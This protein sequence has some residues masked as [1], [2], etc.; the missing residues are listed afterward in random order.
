MLHL[1]HILYVME[2]KH[3]GKKMESFKMWCW[4]TMNKISCNDLVKNVILRKSR[5]KL[6][7]I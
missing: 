3:F 1:E 2:L 7:S 6:H 4:R 5:R